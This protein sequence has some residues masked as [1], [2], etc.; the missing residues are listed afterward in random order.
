[1]KKTKSMR[2]ALGLLALILITSC[3]VGGTFAKY[4]TSGTAEDTARV[5]KFGVKVAA[6]GSAFAETYAADE[7][8][9]EDVNG[10]VI[11]NSV[12]STEA[13]ND[14]I[15]DRVVAPGTKGNMATF[16]ITGTPEVAVRVTYAATMT[17]SENWKDADGN[18]YCPIMIKIGDKTIKQGDTITPATGDAYTVDSAA[19]FQKAVTETL[20]SYTQ[21]YKALTDLSTINSSDK[22]PSFSWEWAFVGSDVSDDFANIQT[23]VRDTY[24]GDQAAEG[25]AATIDLSVSATVTQID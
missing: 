23:D 18:F 1:M 24:L 11:S 8:N 14:E 21:N 2:V 16:T 10:D 3:F 5:A 17:L 19:N 15:D 6:S 13:S 4:T 12:I 25:N 22:A 7:A 20:A 9:V